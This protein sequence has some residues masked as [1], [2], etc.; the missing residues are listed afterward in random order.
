MPTIEHAALWTPDLER[1]RAFYETYFDAT[2]G[3]KY[4]NPD[5]GFSS[6]FL[7]FDDG[8]RLELM[9]T[10]GLTAA[11]E[12]PATGYGHVA[13]AVGSE[14]QVDRLTERLGDEGVPVLDGPR[15]TGDGYYESVVADPDGNRVEITA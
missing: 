4:V 1:V 13:I 5:R 9:H 7:T 11:A 2:A 6:Y 8:A 3:E 10:P 15:R 12:H 14:A